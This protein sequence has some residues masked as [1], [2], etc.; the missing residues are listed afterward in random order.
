MK[1]E[2]KFLVKILLFLTLLM[3]TIATI[4]VSITIITTSAKL[5]VIRDN[6]S[7]YN[8]QIIKTDDM[9]VEYKTNVEKREQI[10]NSENYV[11]REFSNRNLLVKFVVLV[12]AISTFFWLPYMWAV[13][14]AERIRKLRK[15][16]RRTQRYYE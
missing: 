1:N 13:T 16:L 9:T 2:R 12:L 3:G 6:I 14:I 4:N 7:F 11:E 5:F 8:E 15:R 10:Y